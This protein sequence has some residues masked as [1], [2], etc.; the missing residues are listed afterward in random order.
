MFRLLKRCL[1][2][3]IDMM[4]VLI[5]VQTITN[6]SFINKN[7]DKYNEVYNDYLETTTEYTSF[8]LDLIKKY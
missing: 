4:V 7:L 1:A 6:I 3:F 5:I 2:Y 8:R